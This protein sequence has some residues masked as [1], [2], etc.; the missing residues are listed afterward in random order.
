MQSLKE[1]IVGRVAAEIEGPPPQSPASFSDLQLDVFPAE[2]QWQANI[3]DY[4]AERDT[5][6]AQWYHQDP[7]G[8]GWA[9][10]PEISTAVD[11]TAGHGRT[12]LRRSRRTSARC[13]RRSACRRV[14]TRSRSIINGRRAAEGTV[15]STFTD[16]EAFLAR[17]LTPA[18]CRPPD[19][20]RRT[21]AI[22]GLI[23]G[24]NSADGQYGVYVARYGIPGI[25]SSA[26]RSE[27]ADGGP[28][29]RPRSSRGSRRSRR[30]TRRSGTTNDYFEGLTRS[31]VAL[32]RLR[33]RDTCRSAPA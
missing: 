29:R 21:D 18:F 14:S 27:R 10:I 11:P 7:Q 19:W 20:V 16:Y 1:H 25:A 3:A 13:R 17:D 28:D 24:F 33:H 23:D 5:I 30:T 2:V 31:G 12:L 22:P 15:Q 4:D 32:V 6:S 9:I 26:A 8:L